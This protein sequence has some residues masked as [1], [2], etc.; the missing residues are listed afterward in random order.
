M[1]ALRPF[2]L[3]SCT[4][5]LTAVLGGWGPTAFGL[6][7]GNAAANANPA[8]AAAPPTA[9][10]Y[11]SVPSISG[12]PGNYIIGYAAAP[13]GALVP[14]GG[15]PFA[16]PAGL[17]QITADNRFLYSNNF[18]NGGVNIT[19][20]SVAPN[21]SLS[22]GT[23]TLMQSSDLQSVGQSTAVAF[24]DRTGRNLYDLGQGYAALPGGNLDFVGFLIS[25]GYL[26][27]NDLSF[28]LD[29][30]FAYGADFFA[31]GPN[32]YG[33]TRNSDSSLTSFN[34]NANLPA[35]APDQ[36][37]WVPYGAA[38]PDNSHVIFAMQ[39]GAQPLQNAILE[40]LAVYT[41]NPKDGTLTTTDTAED[42]PSLAVGYAND[43]RFDPSGRWLAAGGAN[44]VE[45]FAFRNGVLAPTGSVLNNKNAVTQLFWDNAGHLFTLSQDSYL[46]WV[47][48]VVKGVP[49]PAPGSPYTIPVSNFATPYLTV[50]P[51][52]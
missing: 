23:S 52:R 29:D 16:T 27:Q 38:V 4:F 28:T 5:T 19:S 15:S 17:Y 33:F 50:Q 45:I 31:G 14:I 18:A 32:F 12:G 10:V 20:W 36:N 8:P 48:D 51:L 35:P 1:R 43:Y 47:Y 39:N 30:R 26:N 37:P 49:T 44:G 6:N 7:P 2:L 41:I 34:T 42:M 13:N 21:G 25:N 22:P 3:C 24:T 46:L 9:F 40:Q 11:V